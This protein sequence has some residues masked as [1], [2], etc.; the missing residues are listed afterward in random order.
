MADFTFKRTYIRVFF[1]FVILAGASLFSVWLVGSSENT[2]RSGSGAVNPVSHKNAT[3]S[4]AVMAAGSEKN[5]TDEAVKKYNAELYRLNKDADF[6]AG[7]E[8]RV[9]MPDEVFVENFLNEEASQEL[10]FPKFKKSD[11]K[12][13]PSDTDDDFTIYMKA[14]QAVLK[15]NGEGPTLQFL[16]AVDRAVQND[17]YGELKIHEKTADNQVKGLLQIG[18]PES[19]VELH[20]AFLNLWQGRL[21]VARAILNSGNDPI[22][23]VAAYNTLEKLSETE[24][25]FNDFLNKA[26]SG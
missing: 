7:G 9:N 15:K 11:L 8:T 22:G 4:S 6:A 25:Q 2:A 14:L 24:V 10:D 5:L 16:A 12:M 1:S 23:A 20:L 18:V 19:A 13:T 26:F 17:D 21:Y 3:V